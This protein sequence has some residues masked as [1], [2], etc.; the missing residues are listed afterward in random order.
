[1]SEAVCFHIHILSSW[2]LSGMGSQECL[3]KVQFCTRPEIDWYKS[4]IMI[5]LRP[6]RAEEPAE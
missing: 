2:F 1:M 4:I 5:F 6:G 3:T